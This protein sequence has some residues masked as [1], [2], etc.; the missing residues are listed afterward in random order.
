MVTLTAVFSVV[1]VLKTN[2][3]V[4]L[5]KLKCGIVKNYCVVIKYSFAM[6]TTT[7]QSQKEDVGRV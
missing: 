5:S 6:L 1:K 3:I 7:C 2:K 4:K